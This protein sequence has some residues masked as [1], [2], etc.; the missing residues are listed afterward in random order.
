MFC[1]IRVN[2]V[3]ILTLKD[4]EENVLISMCQTYACLKMLYTYFCFKMFYFHL[5]HS[6]GEGPG[7]YNASQWLERL[8]AEVLNLAN[9]KQKSLW[10]PTSVIL[11]AKHLKGYLLRKSLNLPICKGWT[12][13][14]PAWRVSP[15]LK[16]SSSPRSYSR[17]A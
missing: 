7:N 16:K 2:D 10:K 12:G 8:R 4:D 15:P 5:I 3:E 1:I 17:G 13:P 11:K 9:A 6:L 14:S